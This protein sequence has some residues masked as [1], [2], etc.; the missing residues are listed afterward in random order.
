MLPPGA[1]A[2]IDEPI[3]EIVGYTRSP[4]DVLRLLVYGSVA[5]VL[6]ALT[7]WATTAITGIQHDLA[8]LLDTSS[9]LQRLL[10][11]T[12]QIVIGLVTLLVFVPAFVLQRYR[13]LGY[14][15]VGNALNVILFSAAVAWLDRGGLHHIANQVARDAT[16]SGMLH[17]RGLGQIA[18]S[19]I[20]LAP[21]VSSRWRRS[22]MGLIVVFAMIRLTTSQALPDDVFVALAVGATA[23]CLVLLA[24]G[25]PER[26]ATAAGVRQALA[27]TGL[28]VDHL[29]PAGPDGDQ[30]MYRVDVGRPEMVMTK[31]LS[32]AERS[33]DVLYR[34][35]R[36]IRLKDIGDER[37][38]SSLRRTV[39]HEALIALQARDVGVRTPASSRDRGGRQ[40]FHADRV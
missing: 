19:F 37:P 14:I 13:L 25:R 34:T 11:G 24:F 28:P 1:R 15:V 16:S 39:E 5:L 35:Y 29:E 6:L 31:V 20:I 36:L 30:T 27:T 3:E 9:T 40:R 38:F 26:R 21:F 7:R 2:I 32:P 10:S 4:S 17:P 18:A 33:A 8:N 23:G 12:A 22:G